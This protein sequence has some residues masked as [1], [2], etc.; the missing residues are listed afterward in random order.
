M[1]KAEAWKRPVIHTM[2]A[3]QLYM[4]RRYEFEMRRSWPVWSYSH[5]LEKL[6]NTTNDA[7]QVCRY[8][9]RDWNWVRREYK[10]RAWDW[11]KSGPRH[12]DLFISIL[13]RL[14]HQLHGL[15]LC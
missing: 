8:P 15:L 12:S 11:Y 7:T 5:L 6:N 4:M 3:D 9:R 1:T 2:S 10:H 14:R 13:N